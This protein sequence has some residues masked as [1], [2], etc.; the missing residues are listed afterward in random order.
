[1]GY[2][3]FLFMSIQMV[4]TYCTRD[5][6]KIPADH[7]PKDLQ[8]MGRICHNAEERKRMKRQLDFVR[9][10][11]Q[12]GTKCVSHEGGFNAISYL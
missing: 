11:P 9:R 12:I 10:C 5:G 6:V 8:A 7:Q 4:E 2:G 1:M 3:N